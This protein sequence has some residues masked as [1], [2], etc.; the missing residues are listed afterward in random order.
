M[1][2]VTGT[3]RSGTSLWMQLLKAAEVPVLGVEFPSVWGTSIREANPGGFYE[4]KLRSGIYYATNPDPVT[5]RFVPPRETRTHAAKVFIPGMVRT[6]LAYMNRV[7]CTIRHWRDYGPSMARL[8]D[9]EDRYFLGTKG[10]EF[11][12]ARRVRRAQIPRHIE[13]FM[14]YYELL[15][16][17]SVRRYPMRVVAYERLL[18]EPEPVLTSVFG[19]L[20]VTNVEAAIPLVKP[21][22]GGHG[23]GPMPEGLTAERA[24]AFEHLWRVFYEEQPLTPEFIASLDAIHRALEEEFGTL[25]RDRQV[26]DAVDFDR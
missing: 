22:K 23:T 9:L 25:S 19:W 2:L 18:A 7:V 16:D 6:D 13:W 24:D 3:K 8:N 20:G 10:A 17:V 5:G 4:S 15:R 26:D 12:E 11:V 1:I 21:R 14:E